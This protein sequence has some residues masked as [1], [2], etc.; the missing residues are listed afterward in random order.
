MPPQ[1]LLQLT[2]SNPSTHDIFGKANVMFFGF[3]YTLRKCP[4]V[5]QDINIPSE[6]VMGDMRYHRRTVQET[7]EH[8]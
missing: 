4:E 2:G 7:G 6:A 5:I 8:L 1:P 3:D